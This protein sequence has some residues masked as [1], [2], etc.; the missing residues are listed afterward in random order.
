MEARKREGKEFANLLSLKAEGRKGG[1]YS[2]SPLL[3]LS[4]ATSDPI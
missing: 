2:Y 4:M 3:V 1:R